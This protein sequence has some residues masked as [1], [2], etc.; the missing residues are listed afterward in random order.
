MERKQS[1][2]T[3]ARRR[4][5]GGGMGSVQEARRRRQAHQQQ[6][7]AACTGSA[8]LQRRLRGPEAA[9]GP[10][11]CPADHT[12]KHLRQ[13]LCWQGACGQAGV[14]RR[15]AGGMKWRRVAISAAAA[16]PTAQLSLAVGTHA[17][18]FRSVWAA[19]PAYAQHFQICA[20]IRALRGILG[21]PQPCSPGTGGPQAAHRDG[22]HAK[23]E[24]DGA[25]EGV[26]VQQAAV[27]LLTRRRLALVVGCACRGRRR[28]GGEAR[29]PAARRAAGNAGSGGSGTAP[30]SP[31]IPCALTLGVGGILGARSL[32]PLAGHQVLAFDSLLRVAQRGVFGDLHDLL[33]QLLLR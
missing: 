24:A 11:C 10:R 17:P 28:Q 1:W 16:A 13:K 15:T 29:R 33:H 8:A 30:H 18:P 27:L 9:G 6:G 4:G 22:A 7:R 32:L 31:P 26:I 20:A 12:W 3:G 23:V 25:L 5:G 2:M 21:A 14:R 19:Q